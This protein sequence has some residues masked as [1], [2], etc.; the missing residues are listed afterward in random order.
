[1]NVRKEAFVH[2]T[3]QIVHKDNKL[4]QNNVMNT[5]EQ[6]DQYIYLGSIIDENMKEIWKNMKKCEGIIKK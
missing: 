6:V 3:V 4:P 2:V 5:Y 1:M